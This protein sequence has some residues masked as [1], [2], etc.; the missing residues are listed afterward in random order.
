MK[1]GKTIAATDICALAFGFFLGL[2]I[3]KFGDPVILDQKIFPP[4]SLSE[5]ISDSWPTHWA[6]WIFFPLAAVVAVVCIS[7]P[8]TD[9]GNRQ[10]KAP[11]RRSKPSANDSPSPGGEG[12]GEGEL[13][14]ANVQ[15][16]VRLANRKWLF[17]LPLL[18]LGWQFISATQTVDANL[19][20]ATLWQLAGC[21]ACFFIGALI[22]NTPR[23]FN[24]LLPGIFVAL[25]IC[26]IFAVRQRIEY[27]QDAKFMIQEQN[28][29]WTNLPPQSV[30]EM[31]RDQTIITTNGVDIVNPVI[32]A[33]FQKGRVMGTMIY[34]NALAEI[35]LLLFPIAF[36]LTIRNTRMLRPVVRHAA[37]GLSV[38]LAVAA[39][40]WSGSKFGWL[41]AIVIGGLC[42][43]R[44]PWPIKYKAAALALVAVLGMSVFA[45]RF[46]SYFAHGATSAVARLDYWRAAVQTTV[47][48]PVVGTGPGTFQRPYAEIKSPN[49]EMA[50]LAHNDYLEQFSDSG[51]PGGL[52]YCAWVAAALAVTG[53]RAWKSPGQV[54][55]VLFLGLLGWCIQEFGEFG[56]YIPAEAWIAFMFLGCAMAMR[57]VEPL[58]TVKR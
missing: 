46:H 32:L 53:A 50:R 54:E 40:F 4:T 57:K 10:T 19:T 18:W 20:A 27:P 39:F 28:L 3:L 47:S 11:A 49:A 17:L 24:F 23:R 21:V 16:S 33:K 48:H 5:M 41:I 36:V 34:P 55:F 58:K 52:F 12:R 22:F 42:L 26:L 9:G 30:E 2:C 56:L 43:F 35:I 29:G 44:L 25:A 8:S 7:S 38:A 45:V 51:F 6:N 14:T 37:V 13:I 15:G 31:R 1:S